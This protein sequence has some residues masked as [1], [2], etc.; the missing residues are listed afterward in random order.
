LAP[1][2]AGET[3]LSIVERFQDDD[4]STSATFELG[5]VVTDG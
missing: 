5:V 2:A 3:S 4:E 1:V